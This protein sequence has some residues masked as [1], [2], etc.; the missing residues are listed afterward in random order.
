MTSDELGTRIGALISSGKCTLGPG[1]NRSVNSHVQDALLFERRSNLDAAAHH[2]L[3]AEVCAGVMTWEQFE[4]VDP[5]RKGQQ[6][7]PI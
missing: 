7:M 2:L 6:R 3:L 5:F 1:Y 4:A